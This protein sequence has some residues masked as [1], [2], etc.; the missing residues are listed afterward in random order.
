MNRDQ[1]VLLTDLLAGWYQSFASAVGNRDL[2]T[3]AAQWA[4]CL[5][6]RLVG[7]APFNASGLVASLLTAVEMLHNM[8]DSRVFGVSASQGV[9]SQA[10]RRIALMGSTQYREIASYAAHLNTNGA[11]K[12]NALLHP[13]FRALYLSFYPPASQ[14]VLAWGAVITPTTHPPHGMGSY[15]NSASP[16]FNAGASV[17]TTL[18]AGSIPIVSWTGVTGDGLLVINGEWRR[19]DGSLFVGQA[20]VLIPN[21]SSGWAVISTLPEPG[22]VLVRVL[23]IVSCGASGGVFHF[24]GT[25]GVNRFGSPVSDL[26]A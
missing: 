15:V 8:T 22:V 16:T 21:A 12:W 4:E 14:T 2:D 18:Y 24:H 25:L 1:L 10:N 17:D 3:G 19:T 5:R 26:C 13:A 9:L 11:P 20:S 23:G 6:S 7:G